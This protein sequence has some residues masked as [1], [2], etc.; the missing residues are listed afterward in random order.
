MSRSGHGAR[1]RADVLDCGAAEAVGRLIS[2]VMWH[3]GGRCRSRRAAS[4]DDDGD[5][6]SSVDCQ[7][8]RAGAASTVPAD[9]DAQRAA[10]RCRLL[11]VRDRPTNRCAARRALRSSAYRRRGGEGACAE[12]VLAE[13]ASQPTKARRAAG[14]IR[15]TEADG[16]CARDAPPVRC[17]WLALGCCACSVCNLTRLEQ[18]GGRSK[19]SRTVNTVWALGSH[20]PCNCNA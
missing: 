12:R 1:A 17:C 8:A 16:D 6:E 11:C 20:V 18:P 3:A 7:W 5:G 14:T 9:D 15:R 10:K 19:R 4:R 13:R 2:V